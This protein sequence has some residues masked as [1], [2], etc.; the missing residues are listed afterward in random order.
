MTRIKRGGGHE[1]WGNLAN[2]CGWFLGRV[3]M[4]F[5]WLEIHTF[6]T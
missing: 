1:I 4:L 5:F 3:A 2:G 6:K